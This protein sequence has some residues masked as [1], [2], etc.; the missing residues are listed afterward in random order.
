MRKMK[1]H[2]NYILASLCLAALSA[3]LSGG[4]ATVWNGPVITY[5]QPSPDPTQAANRD[6]LTPHVSLTRAATSGMFNGVTET[7]YTHNLSPADTEWA[8]GALT[9]YV[10]LT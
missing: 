4:A 10:T 6:Q 2:T 9:N 8:V 1:L 5:T 3:P 7:F